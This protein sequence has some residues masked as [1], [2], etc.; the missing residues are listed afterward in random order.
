MRIE[1]PAVLAAFLFVAATPLRA[2]EPEKPTS[3]TPQQADV[4]DIRE[5]LDS[6]RTIIEA[7]GRSEAHTADAPERLAEAVRTGKADADSFAVIASWVLHAKEE[8]VARGVSAALSGV[9]LRSRGPAGARWEPTTQA[10]VD[11]LVAALGEAQRHERRS[12]DRLSPE[13]VRLVATARPAIAATLREMDPAALASLADTARALGGAPMG[14][15]VDGMLEALRRDE[16][17]GP[18]Q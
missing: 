4:R 7:M 8:D 16:R 14:D 6:L 15:L 9:D 10:M 13:M 1:S 5:G 2:A 12:A 18:R 17:E 3:E 11:V